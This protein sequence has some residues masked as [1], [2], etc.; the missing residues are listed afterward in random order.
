MICETPFER[1]RVPQILKGIKSFQI[2]RFWIIVVKSLRF[3]GNL[4]FKIY[5]KY[6]EIT[7]LNVFELNYIT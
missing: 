1:V 2:I 4:A 6:C 3:R 7:I 5:P